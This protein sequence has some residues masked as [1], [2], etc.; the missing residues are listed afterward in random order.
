ML[1]NQ[2]QSLRRSLIAEEEVLARP[3]QKKALERFTVPMKMLMEAYSNLVDYKNDADT[4]LKSLQELKELLSDSN[5]KV[6]SNTVQFIEQ[7]SQKDAQSH[8]LFHDQEVIQQLINMLHTDSHLQV[9]ITQILN[10]LSRFDAGLHMITKCSAIDALINAVETRIHIDVAFNSVNLIFKILRNDEKALNKSKLKSESSIKILVSLVELNGYKKEET[11][12]SLLFDCLTKIAY[13]NEAV[14]SVIGQ[15]GIA[16]KVMKVAMKTTKKSLILAS[17]RLF[18]VLSVSDELK[19]SFI[20][21]GVLMLLTDYL[22]EPL[23]DK[24]FTISLLTLMNLSDFAGREDNIEMLMRRLVEILAINEHR[25]VSECVACVLLNF[26]QKD[27][28]FV[29]RTKLIELNLIDV[30]KNILKDYENEN[31][32]NPETQQAYSMFKKLSLN[33]HQTPVNSEKLVLTLDSAV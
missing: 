25:G 26:T 29:N 10:N 23:N 15:N 20:N 18:R 3:S 17:L 16:A 1:T 24:M 19:L 2:R 31:S 28:T 5:A 12:L 13:G 4:T 22:L 27:E 7:L 32:D 9:T 21:N 11:F 6:R 33:L 30:L 8:A 14:K